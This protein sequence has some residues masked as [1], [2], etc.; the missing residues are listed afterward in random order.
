MTTLLKDDLTLP[1][2]LMAFLHNADGQPVQSAR[3]PA[4]SAAAELG[5]LVLRGYVSIDDDQVSTAAAAP[6][7]A[8]P[9]V[10]DLLHDLSRQEPVKVRTWVRKRRTALKVQQ[11]AALDAGVLSKTRGK[12]FGLFGYD[13][14]EPNEALRERIL[15]ELDSPEAAAVPRAQALAKL[16]LTPALRRALRFD[17]ARVERLTALVNAADGTPLPGP[18]FTTMDIAIAS[19]VAVGVLGE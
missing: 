1:E 15:G 14:L 10:A 8:R 7:T 9:W 13:R 12:L 16:L 2:A 17:D 5:E 4:L 18:L 6:A 19:G 3:P 11:S